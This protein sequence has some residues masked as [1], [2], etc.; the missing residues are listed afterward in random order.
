[1]DISPLLRKEPDWTIPRVGDLLRDQRERAGLSQTEFARRAGVSPRTVSAI[2]RGTR[3]PSLSVL[4]HLLTGIGRQ[5]SLGTEPI[6][7]PEAELDAA[8]AVLRAIPPSERLIGPDL[9]GPALLR[10]LAPA[11]PVVEGPAAALLHGA[12]VPCPALDVVVERARLRDLAEV[13]RR[14]YAERWSDVWERWGAEAPQPQVP[15]PPRWRTL[16]GE[17]R[18]RF[19][20]ERPESVT[21]LVGDLP[22]AVRPLHLVAA[23][24]RRVALALNR[25]P[26]APRPDR[27]PRVPRPTMERPV[28]QPS[29]GRPSERCPTCDRTP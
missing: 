16:D 4:E 3:R 23:A 24:D 10:L 13:F 27:P 26:G 11:D 8:I 9:D 21:V 19:V 28:T 20:D 2:E 29:V 7:M 5:L 17:M 18:V 22:V 6:D 14:S 1:M 12:P 25:L 15:G